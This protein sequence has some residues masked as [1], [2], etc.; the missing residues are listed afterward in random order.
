MS[1]WSKKPEAPPFNGDAMI[2]PI[3][4]A[5]YAVSNNLYQIL[6]AY[7]VHEGL[8]IS[9]YDPAAKVGGLLHFIRPDSK[10]EPEKAKAVPA[11]FADTGIAAFL[12]DLFKT[13][14]S[15][16]GLQVKLAGGG[17][18]FHGAPGLGQ[19]NVLSAK[20]ALWK[21]SMVVSNEAVGGPVGLHLKLDMSNGSVMV[22]TRDQEIQ[23]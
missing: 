12:W 15:R 21:H 2:T 20:R 23:L 17:E 18:L 3:S 19:K 9:V 7:P 13:G 14:A 22:K 16:K 4:Q 1:G 6:V 10:E 5:A 11:M 8:G